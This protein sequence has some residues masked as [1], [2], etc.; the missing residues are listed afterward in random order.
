MRILLLRDAR[1]G[2]YNQSEGLAAALAEAMPGADH[3]WD[4]LLE[5]LR[6]PL[7]RAGLAI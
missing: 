3:P 1:P 4:T 5:G 6:P 2:H 7:A